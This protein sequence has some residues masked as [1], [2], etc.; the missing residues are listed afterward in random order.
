LTSPAKVTRKSVV[1][2]DV[3]GAMPLVPARIARHVSS[4]VRPTAVISPRPV[5]ATLRRSMPTSLHIRIAP[6]RDGG[7]AG[8]G[9]V[10]S[11]KGR[12]Y[13]SRCDSR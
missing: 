13:A 4:R 1:S 3:I 8:P 11:R 12:G 10:R 7:T 9:T 5:I 6:V 2:K